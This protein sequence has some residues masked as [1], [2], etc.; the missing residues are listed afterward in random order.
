MV[1]LAVALGSALGAA[2]RFALAL[3]LAAALGPAFAW[4]TLAANGLGSFLIGLYAAWTGPGG[5]RQA[6]PAEAAFVMAGF[7]GGFTTF[8]IFSLEVVLK[9]EAGAWQAAAIFFAGSLAIWAVG[10][11]AG[12]ALGRR[13]AASRSARTGAAPD[14]CGPGRR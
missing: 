9:L 2:A 4:G 8:S 11:A 13:I 3:A 7:C 1:A 14:R 5:R 6:S 12:H 10:I